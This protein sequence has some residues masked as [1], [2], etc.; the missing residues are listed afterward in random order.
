MLP[1]SLLP[2]PK[3]NVLD[4]VANASSNLMPVRLQKDG[5]GQ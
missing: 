4:M 3:V 5:T 1:S 2:S